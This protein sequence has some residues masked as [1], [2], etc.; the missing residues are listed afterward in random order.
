MENKK[1]QPRWGE[2]NEKFQELVRNIDPEVLRKANEK[3]KEMANGKP[4]YRF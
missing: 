2:P 1:E 4:L 3:I